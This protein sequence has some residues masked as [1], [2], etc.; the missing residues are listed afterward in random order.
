MAKQPSSRQD[1]FGTEG[2][3]EDG[4]EDMGTRGHSSGGGTSGTRTGGVQGN[5]AG[6]QSRT[7][8]PTNEQGPGET[9]ITG[10]K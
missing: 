1:L 10:K 7:G 8:N 4:D 6:A 3:G 9:E 2:I 5:D